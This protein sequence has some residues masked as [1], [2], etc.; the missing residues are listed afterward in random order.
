[1]KRGEKWKQG[2]QEKNVCL[3]QYQISAPR[4][5]QSTIQHKGDERKRT[6]ME[7]G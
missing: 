2:R 7:V 5:W 3:A 6:E 1:M 4:G